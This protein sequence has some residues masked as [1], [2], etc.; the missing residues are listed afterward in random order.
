M[1]GLDALAAA[2]TPKEDTAA[3]TG[4]VNNLSDEMC[5]KIAQKVLQKLQAGLTE[6]EKPEDGKEAPEDPEAPAEDPE[7]GESENDGD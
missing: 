6:T 4:T 1:K 3:G 5:E 2:C 7:E